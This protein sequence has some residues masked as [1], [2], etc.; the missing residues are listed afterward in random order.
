MDHPLRRGS[1]WPILATPGEEGTLRRRIL[2]L[3]ARF[4]GKTGTLA[5]VNSLSGMVRG[6]E[7]GTRYFSIILNHQLAG[8]GE[9]QRTIDAIALAI[10]DF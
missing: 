8:G 2:P 7:G 10:A 9:A 4:R 5:G 3:A 6:K 1:W